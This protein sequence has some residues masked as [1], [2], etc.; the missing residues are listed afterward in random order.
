MR[1][2]DKIKLIYKHNSSYVVIVADDP[3]RYNVSAFD[4]YLIGDQTGTVIRHVGSVHYMRLAPANNS[5]FNFSSPIEGEHL[6][7]NAEDLTKYEHWEI[8]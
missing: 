5:V 2:A 7:V 8:G 3:N 4:K 6:D 1:T